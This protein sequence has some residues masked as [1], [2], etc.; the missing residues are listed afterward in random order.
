MVIVVEKREFVTVFSIDGS[1]DGTPIA[2][3]TMMLRLLPSLARARLDRSYER[4]PFFDAHSGDPVV[5][6]KVLTRSERARVRT[7]A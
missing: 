3:A 5:R 4:T 1:V 2:V 7:A 6:P